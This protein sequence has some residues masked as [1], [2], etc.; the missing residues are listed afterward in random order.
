MT[1]STHY[2]ECALDC[3]KW[4]EETTNE[5]QKKT[6]VDLA[7]LWVEAASRLPQDDTTAPEGSEQLR[8]LH[9]AK[10]G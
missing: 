5:T 10:V 6:F 2:R 9:A 4:A 1:T 8:R 7:R 3:L